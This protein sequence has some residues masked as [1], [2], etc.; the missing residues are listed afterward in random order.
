MEGRAGIGGVAGR[1]GGAGV[2]GKRGRQGELRLGYGATSWFDHG[3][4]QKLIIKM[5]VL[6][7]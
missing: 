7:S 6:R 5:T 1:E 3:I 4:L 2:G